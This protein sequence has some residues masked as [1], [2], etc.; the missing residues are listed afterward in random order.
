M[1][2]FFQILSNSSFIYK[3]VQQRIWKQT[4]LNLFQGTGLPYTLRIAVPTEL[5]TAPRRRVRKWRY[6][7]TILDLGT[8]WRWVV[9]FTSR[10]IYPRGNSLWVGPRAGLD[11]MQ[12]A[13][14][15]Y[16]DWVI[17]APCPQSLLKSAKALTH[18][19]FSLGRHSKPKHPEWEPRHVRYLQVTN[20]SRTHK[21][22]AVNAAEMCLRLCAS[23]PTPS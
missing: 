8:R 13:A 17:P 2:A 7:S 1:T 5:S 15:Q 19:G 9:S 16:I 12:P 14:S 22:E 6:S 21:Q 20:L 23:F 10:Q 3:T 4:A 11:I 18:D